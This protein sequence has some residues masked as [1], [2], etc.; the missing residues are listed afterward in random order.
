MVDELRGPVCRPQGLHEGFIESGIELGF[1]SFL[2]V[3][4]LGAAAVVSHAVNPED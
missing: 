4:E 3:L 1:V 2:R